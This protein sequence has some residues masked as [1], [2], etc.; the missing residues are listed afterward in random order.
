MLFF[1]L[2]DLCLPLWLLAGLLIR[3][4]FFAVCRLPD[5]TDAGLVNL[6]QSSR[7]LRE[8]HLEGCALV[9]DE[10]FSAFKTQ[11]PTLESL[12]LDRIYNVAGHGIA[13]GCPSLTNLR[14]SSAKIYAS[15]LQ[16]ICRQCPRLTNL[17]LQTS[18]LHLS[19]DYEA[20]GYCTRLQELELHQPLALWDTAVVVIL[21]GCKELRSLQLPNWDTQNLSSVSFPGHKNL[22][23]LNLD[24]CVGLTVQQ[25]R[26][27]VRVLFP[28]LQRLGIRSTKAVDWEVD[29]I[30]DDLQRLKPSL[31][32]LGSTIRDVPQTLSIL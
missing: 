13:D 15:G 9:T 22:T 3:Q 31:Q 6:T 2:S 26:D 18:A 4:L 16:A 5:L 14:C 7:S 23:F 29:D 1:Q 32:V 28:S 10:S 19:A 24:G 25:V 12:T 27:F 8:I 30:R 21:N 17:S 20:I 11:C